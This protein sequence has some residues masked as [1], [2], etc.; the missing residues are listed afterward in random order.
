MGAAASVSIDSIRQKLE[1]DVPATSDTELS[2][3]QTQELQAL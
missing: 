2:E 3:E 1:V